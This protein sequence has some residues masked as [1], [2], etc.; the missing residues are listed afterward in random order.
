MKIRKNPHKAKNHSCY[1]NGVNLC[2]A[3]LDISKNVSDMESYVFDYVNTYGRMPS[4]R[5]FKNA[6]KSYLDKVR[7]STLLEKKME[8]WQL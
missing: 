3:M 4:V 6:P 7:V 2:E 8:E 1:Q 5:A